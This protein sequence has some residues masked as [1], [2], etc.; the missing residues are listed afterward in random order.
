MN[1]NCCDM[2]GMGDQGRFPNQGK[3]EQ[4]VIDSER[5]AFLGGLGVFILFIILLIDTHLIN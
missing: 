1:K 4:Q 5:L 3:T 2:D